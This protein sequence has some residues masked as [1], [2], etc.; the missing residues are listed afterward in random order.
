MAL[1][2]YDSGDVFILQKNIGCSDSQSFFV[3]LILAVLLYGYLPIVD[4]F[5]PRRFFEVSVFYVSSSTFS[6]QL[7]AQQ[8][9]VNGWHH[10]LPPTSCLQVSIPLCLKMIVVQLA[11]TCMERLQRLR[12]HQMWKVIDVFLT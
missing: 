9:Q 7:R 5:F 8:I 11:S 3:C 6:T 10:S 4:R 2:T 1:N 12:Y